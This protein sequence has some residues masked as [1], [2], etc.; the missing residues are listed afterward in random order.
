[1]KFIPIA[2]A[3]LGTLGGILFVTNPKQDA[4]AE[5]AAGKL[6]DTLESE[7]CQVDSLGTWLGKIGQGIGEACE[8]AVQ[9]GR[10]AGSDEI[11][12][13]ISAKTETQNYQFFTIY[14]TETSVKTVKFIGV[15]NQFIPLET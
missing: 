1:M 3:T 7:V 2:L 15:L 13:F 5:F 6:V 8:L 10:T 14:T 11:Q 4:Y 9:S 12:S